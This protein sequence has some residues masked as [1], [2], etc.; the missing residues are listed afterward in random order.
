MGNPSAIRVH[1]VLFA[2]GAGA[3]VSGLPGAR[4]AEYTLVPSPQTVHIGYFNAALK[5]VLTIDSG[6]TV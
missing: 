1:L 2:I 5:P 6:D 3:A 4:A